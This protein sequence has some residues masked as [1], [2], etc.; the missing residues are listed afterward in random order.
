M[1]Y[2]NDP[3]SPF[4]PPD[5]TLGL[6]P[7]KDWPHRAGDPPWVLDA[8]EHPKP[9]RN[10][11]VDS[12]SSMDEG[13]KKKKKKKK[14][15][16]CHSKKT[17]DSELKVTTRGEGANTPVWT[18]AGSTKDYSSS[19]DSQSE[20][21]SGLGSNPSFQPCQDTDTEPQ[22]GTNPRTSL[23]PTKKP[24]DDNPL[25]DHGE[26]D[27]DQEIPDANEPQGVNDPADPGPVPGE[28]AVGAQPGDDQVE[29][30]DGEEPQEPLEPYEI[31]LQGF[32]TVSQTLSVAYG[33]AS[34]EI[35]TIVRK[36]LAKTTAEDQTFVWGASG[37]IRHW[38]DSV[39]PAMA[40]REES[41]KDQAQL[42][43]E[44]QQ[45][46]KDALDS[47]LEF[48]PKEQEPQLTPVFPRATHFLAPALAVARR[49]TNEA[50]QNIHTQLVDLA[51]E[52]M[53]EEQV[54]GLFNTIL[55]L[56]CSFQQEMD[57]MATNQVFI[58]TQ[59]IPN[60]WG[61][62][63]G[64]LEGPSLLGP[65]SCSASWPVSLVEWVTVIPTCQN[66]LGLS[67]TPTKS[68]HPLSRA[69]KTT[70]RLRE[71]ITPIR[72]NKLPGYSGG[73]RQEEKKDAEVHKLEEKCQKKSTGP[74][75]SLGD[76]EDSITNLLK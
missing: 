43:A 54:G 72:P 19:S 12:T 35:Q 32:R 44:A 17:G 16:H 68:N 31:I 52:H 22:R 51:K 69:A 73:T 6:P 7:V 29:A 41:T 8:K 9:V 34:S 5:F 20:G 42:L 63:R 56:T 75:L 37:A 53:P 76:H 47:I 67:K 21:D 13:E 26:G 27:G 50:L 30:G 11:L 60:L 46:G 14:K 36:S 18:H 33:A 3:G 4:V 70:S 45:A 57:N 39:R 1:P 25:S 48:I 66:V 55:Q 28:V 10:V 65:P 2:D 40:S 15:K 62:R 74:V 64:L 71:E 23:D 59:I 61:S 24:A 38:L 58:P 49:H